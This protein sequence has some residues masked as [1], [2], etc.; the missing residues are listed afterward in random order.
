[1]STSGIY[2]NI[3]EIRCAHGFYHKVEWRAYRGLIGRLSLNLSPHSHCVANPC[4]AQLQ[5]EKLLSLHRRE[6]NTFF[7]KSQ[8]SS[9]IKEVEEVACL[10][11]DILY[12]ELYKNSVRSI[13]KDESTGIQNGF[14]RRNLSKLKYL[15]KFGVSNHR[16]Y[17]ASSWI[18]RHEK[19]MRRRTIH[20]TWTRVYTEAGLAMKVGCTSYDFNLTVTISAA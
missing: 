11:G 3:K 20:L 19:S 8:G 12:V 16:S 5:L 15:D 7:T 9:E 17:T 4:T 18:E 1:M 2:W 13:K 10:R 14:V 6:Q